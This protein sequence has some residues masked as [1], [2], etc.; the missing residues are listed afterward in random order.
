[1]EAVNSA[2]EAESRLA[3][4]QML[5][6]G[7]H[8]RMTGRQNLSVPPAPLKVSLPGSK[9]SLMPCL[10]LFYTRMAGMWSLFV[11]P[12]A[13]KVGLTVSACSPVLCGS[14]RRFFVPEWRDGGSCQFCTRSRKLD[15]QE[16]NART[17][18]ACRASSAAFP[19]KFMLMRALPAAQ[20]FLSLLLFPVGGMGACR[21][22]L[23][24][25]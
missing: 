8:T 14:P 20:I 19:E 24:G 16:A 12:A 2:R 3:R 17:V 7:G 22:R 4:E 23:P 11:P 25:R 9:C 15:C 13:L 6:C 5:S 1:V 10:P 18:S 21:A